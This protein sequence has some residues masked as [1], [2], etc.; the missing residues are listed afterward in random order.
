MSKTPLGPLAES[1][2]TLLDARVERTKHHH[3]LDIVLIAICAV[4]CGAEGWVEVEAFGRTKNKRV[5]RFLALLHGTRSASHD[6]FGRVFAALE[7]AE[8]QR[9]FSGLGAAVNVL[10]AGQVMALDGKALRRSHDQ[11][12]GKAL[13][14]GQ[15]R[16]A[17][18]PL[19]IGPRKLIA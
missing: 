17:R 16:Q 1:F 18:S 9:C 8:F 14:S 11:R 13:S 12:Q 5:K 10:M 4:I 2:A 15:A 6:T 19:Q 3:L 7:A